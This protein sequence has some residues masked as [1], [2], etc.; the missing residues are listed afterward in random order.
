M[1]WAVGLVDLRCPFLFSC[2]HAIFH[3]DD[4]HCTLPLLLSCT[5]SP[6]PYDSTSHIGYILFF[7]SCHCDVNAFVVL[8]HM[9]F[10]ASESLMPSFMALCPCTFHHVML[11]QW[12]AMCS[13]QRVSCL[14]SQRFSVC[15]SHR[16][17]LGLGSCPQ[18]ML[19]TWVLEGGISF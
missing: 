7:W 17:Y 4:T 6:I 12:T 19:G 1:H 5:V 3:Q 8:T 10:S 13:T 11:C 16:Q 2:A 18:T 15:R 14:F 9:I